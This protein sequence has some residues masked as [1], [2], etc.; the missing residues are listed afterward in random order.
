MEARQPHLINSS[1]STLRADRLDRASVIVRPT[2][3]KS[4]SDCAEL[5][6]MHSTRLAP[7]TEADS[8]CYSL[9]RKPAVSCGWQEPS[10][11][12]IWPVLRDLTIQ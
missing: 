3:L 8:P 11:P 4:L 12:C 1:S 7:P 10:A 9:A 5:A 2:E 6:E